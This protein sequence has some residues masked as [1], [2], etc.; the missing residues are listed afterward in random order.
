MS[1]PE[2]PV[3]AGETAHVKEGR[4]WSPDEAF[5]HCDLL[6]AEHYENFPVGSRWIPRSK[7]KYV[8]A[9]YAFARIADDFADEARYDGSRMGRLHDWKAQMAE[10]YQGKARHPV[11]VALRETVERFEIPQSLLADLLTAF[12]QDVVKSRYANFEEVLAYCHN[13][14]NPVGRLVLL[15]FEYKQE[16]LHQ[17]SDHICTGLQLANFWQDVAID[18]EKDRIYLPRDE[19]ERFGVDEGILHRGEMTD[20][21]RDL[22]AFQVERTRGIFMQGRALPAQ[23]DKRLSLELKLVW[24]GGMRILEKLERAG[25]DFHHRRPTIGAADK[26]L[27][28]W[29]AFRWRANE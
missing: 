22:M 12:E 7:R 25:F 29:R 13:S 17:L 26:F 11:F 2:T 19:Q 28:L 4:L 24:L 10:C 21:L 23:V 18:L 8:H 15:L 1:I 14:A 5:E 6:A 20:N 27:L 16:E 9:I 3:P